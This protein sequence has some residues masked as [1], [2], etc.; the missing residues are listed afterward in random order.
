M[1]VGY[2]ATPPKIRHRLPLDV[3]L[4]REVYSDDNLEEGLRHYDE[5]TAQ[6]GIYRGAAS[7]GS[8]AR[9]RRPAP[10][11][12]EQKAGRKARPG[13]AAGSARIPRFT[14][15]ASTRLAAWPGSTPTGQ[16]FDNNLKCLGGSFEFESKMADALA[17]AIL[18]WQPRIPFF[19]PDRFKK[20]PP[21][22]WTLRVSKAAYH[23]P[24]TSKLHHTS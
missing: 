17:S 15:G 14:A 12:L 6:S 19:E 9:P 1:T 13:K 16:S 7:G 2:P 20:S 5:V 10:A 3:I 11:T 18:P 21:D 4:H 23:T 8:R 22:V 24:A